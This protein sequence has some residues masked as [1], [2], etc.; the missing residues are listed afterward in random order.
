ME[1]QNAKKRKKKAQEKMKLKKL[2]T[3]FVRPNP[4]DEADIVVQ[5]GPG[6]RFTGTI[7]HNH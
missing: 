7:S 4:G 2:D 3:Y 5:R 6:A 1:Q